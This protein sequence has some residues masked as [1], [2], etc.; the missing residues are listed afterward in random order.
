MSHNSAEVHW[1]FH[2]KILYKR[3]KKLQAKALNST[4]RTILVWKLSQ[5]V[6]FDGFQEK[7]KWEEMATTSRVSPYTSLVL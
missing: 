1:T 7:T 4:C 6:N 2:F 5:N 3:L